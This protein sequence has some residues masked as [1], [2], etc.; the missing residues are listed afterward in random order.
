M[1]GAGFFLCRLLAV[2]FPFHLDFVRGAGLMVALASSLAAAP[3]LLKKNM[4]NLR[5]T[6]PAAVLEGAGGIVGA[7]I[8]L[9]LPTHIVQICMGLVLLGIAGLLL[10][11]KRVENPEVKQ[12]DSL[13]IRLG[14][15][16]SYQ[17]ESTGQQVNWHVHR[18]AL[19]LLSFAGIGIVAGMFGLGAGWASVPVLNLVM[20]AP[21]KVA[22]ACS[23]FI[24]ASGA[25][26]AAWIYINK[27]VV[28][29]ILVIPSIAGMILGAKVGAKLLAKTKPA[30]IRYIVISVMLLS[31]LRS[32]TQGFGL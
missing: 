6:V 11:V 13:A 2:F 10:T 20:G 1:S 9:A 24:L 26:S 12:P 32:L 7:I 25:T 3:I 15:M 22:V 31:S 16:G 21:L 17:E 5:L 30:V 4:V 14:I 29:P 18:T 8:G 27:G 28:L 19:G 23:S